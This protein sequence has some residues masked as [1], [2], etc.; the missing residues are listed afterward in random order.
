MVHVTIR[1][2]YLD[3]D[4]VV[5]HAPHNGHDGDV[6]TAWWKELS[7]LL[8]KAADVGRNTLLLT[9]ANSL[10]AI[11]QDGVCG[12]HQLAAKHDA[13]SPEFI[14]ALAAGRLFLPS[15]FSCFA[16]P[17]DHMTWLSTAAVTSVAPTELLD[18]ALVK[19]DHLA[20]VTE[21]TVEVSTARPAR[22]RRKR[23]PYCRW[24]VADLWK[25][26][27][28]ATLLAE[29]A[30]HAHA[31]SADLDVDEHC[32]RIVDVVRG[33]AVEAF[34]KTVS[35]PR[36]R[37]FSQLAWQIREARVGPVKQIRQMHAI[38]RLVELKALFLC[39]L[40][41]AG[42]F[43]VEHENFAGVCATCCFRLA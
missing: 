37:W 40:R 17:H 11:L 27:K 6:R 18:V 5:G 36:A 30:E 31:Q 33:A 12:D 26:L 35:A 16:E 21:I 7:C 32:D 3:V 29:Q 8:R 43:C 2:E 28:F 42:S 4:D 24:P 20:V 23:L 14:K 1:A 13:N 39:W 25:R 34:P 38:L 9:D 41:V 19:V 10:I 15:T 22:L